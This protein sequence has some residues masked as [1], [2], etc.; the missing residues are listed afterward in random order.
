MFVNPFS[1]AS[2]ITFSTSANCTFD[3]SLVALINLGGYFFLKFFFFTFV[4]FSDFFIKISLHYNNYDYN[5]DNDNY[6]HYH[7]SV[8]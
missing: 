5:N 2:F 6:N 7:K 4:S 3:G 8:K 1:N